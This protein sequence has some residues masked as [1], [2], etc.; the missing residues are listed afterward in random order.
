MAYAHL[1]DRVGTAVG[2]VH[3]IQQNLPLGG[4]HQTGD[5]HQRRGLSGAVGT[6]QG[7]DAVVRHLKRDTVQCR[8]VSVIHLEIFHLQHKLPLRSAKS[9]AFSEIG[10]LHLLVVLN[11]LRIALAKLLTV[12]QHHNVV[13]NVHNEFQVML[14]DDYR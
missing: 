14:N 3:I 4:I 2:N 1:H 10:F 9:G 11:F 6:D 5:R 8:N 12:V 7:N 13:A